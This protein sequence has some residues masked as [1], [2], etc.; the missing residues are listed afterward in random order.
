MVSCRVHRIFLLL[1]KIHINSTTN[2][3]HRPCCQGRNMDLRTWANIGAWQTLE[4]NFGFCTTWGQ[5]FEEMCRLHIFAAGICAQVTGISRRYEI[6]KWSQ[7]KCKIKCFRM[8]RECRCTLRWSYLIKQATKEIVW[9]EA[10][11]LCIW[12]WVVWQFRWLCTSVAGDC[13]GVCT[14]PQVTY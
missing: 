5:V 9:S 11:A 2:S 4:F 7:I 3:S 6:V 10:H 1:K 13:A 12:S 14:C 8:W